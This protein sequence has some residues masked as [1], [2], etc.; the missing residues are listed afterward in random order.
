MGGDLLQIPL[1]MQQNGERTTPNFGPCAAPPQPAK[2]LQ[3]QAGPV[4]GDT[5]SGA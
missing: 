5:Y 1:Q 4:I 2:S 3:M